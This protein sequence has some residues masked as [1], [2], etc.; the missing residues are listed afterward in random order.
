M[1]RRRSG[2]RPLGAGGFK[3]SVSRAGQCRFSLSKRSLASLILAARTMIFRWASR[4]LALVLTGLEKERKKKKKKNLSNHP[5]LLLSFQRT[6]K[7]PQHIHSLPDPENEAGLS[8]GHLLLK[9][10][11]VIRRERL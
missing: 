3:V 7:K 2:R 8:F 4:T 11:F 1:W 5:V 10:A 9:T 6:S